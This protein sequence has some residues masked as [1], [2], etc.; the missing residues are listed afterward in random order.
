MFWLIKEWVERKLSWLHAQRFY[1]SVMY[2][3]TLLQIVAEEK[4]IAEVDLQ[5][6]RSVIIIVNE[7][8]SEREKKV[9]SIVDHL[10]APGPTIAVMYH[11]RESRL[12]T[13]V[14]IAEQ[15]RQISLHL[16]RLM[17]RKFQQSNG[18]V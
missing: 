4:N 1:H 2:P 9:V 8:P 13:L 10:M 18:G 14:V 3:T 5:S 11:E 16:Q 15:R 17:N 6:K 12:L 7:Y